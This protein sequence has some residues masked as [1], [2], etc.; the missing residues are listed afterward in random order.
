RTQLPSLRRLIQ[1]QSLFP[2]ASADATLLPSA[3]PTSSVL[4][5]RRMRPARIPCIEV[6]RSYACASPQVARLRTM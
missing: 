5:Q 3:Y 2:I 1:S 6:L 4:F